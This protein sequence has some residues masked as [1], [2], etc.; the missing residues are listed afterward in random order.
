MGRPPL[1]LTRVAVRLS[2][3]TI[4]RIDG[5]VGTYGRAQFIREAVEQALEL[6]ENAPELTAAPEDAVGD[7]SGRP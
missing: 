4:G 7:K 3:E 6:K 5:L 1:H 2:P